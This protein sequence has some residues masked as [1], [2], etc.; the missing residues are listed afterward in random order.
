MKGAQ[1]TMTHQSH[2]GEAAGQTDSS[3]KL[4]RLRLPDDLTGKRVLDIGCNE[5][6]FCN[7]AVRRGAANVVGIDNDLN[8]LNDAKRR[9]SAENISFLNQS[10]ASLPEGPFDIVLWTS[11]MHYEL[12][13]A[14]VLGRIAKILAP[15]GVLILE[16]GVYQTSGKEMLYTVRHDGGLWYPSI[17][18]LETSLSDAGLTHRIVSHAETTGAD[19]VPR[20]VFHCS[21]RLPTVM[22]VRGVTKIGKSNLAA[23]LRNDATKIVALDYFIARIGRAKWQH[24]DLQKLIH[25]L[26][27][28]R[29]LRA[30]YLGIDEAGL[31]DTYAS[32]LAKG[33]A[34]TD[35]LVVIEGFMT[36][37]QAER[38]TFHLKGRAVVWDV[39]Q[40]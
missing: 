19:P 23:L 15:G 21:L 10:W 7:E 5:G 1:R 16:C 11:A 12:D 4:L 40:R 17:Q 33:I 34:A 30:T 32:L 29:D 28:G 3:K 9:Y 36:D 37:A 22:L 26:L 38:L 8:Y 20:V 13:P 14:E 27:D 18:F 6:F 24:N 25:R 39:A 35:R 31:T 2:P